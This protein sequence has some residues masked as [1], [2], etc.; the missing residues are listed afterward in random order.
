MKMTRG[1]SVKA[2]LV[3]LGI[4][5]VVV[6][7][8]VARA[9]AASAQASTGPYHAQDVVDHYLSILDA[10]MASGTCDFSALSTVYA[11]NGTLSLTGG[12]FASSGGPPPF[13]NLATLP[14]ATRVAGDVL[15][16]QGLT[17]IEGFYAA[18]C[19]DFGHVL[20]PG[21][22]PG[23]VQDSGFLLS[24]NVLDS[25]EHFNLYKPNGNLAGPGGRCMHVFTIGGDKITSL[26]WSVY[27]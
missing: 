20:P 27:A 17:N 1:W 24:P 6:A 9:G 2:V 10:G 7:A 3:C 13:A 12:P 18:F 4:V 14:G 8:M 25:Y 16:F 5:A 23:W 11:D 22:Y 26:N 21:F 19:G 15:Q